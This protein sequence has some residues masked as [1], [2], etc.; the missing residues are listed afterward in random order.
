[1]E[2]ASSKI[3]QNLVRLT[4]LDMVGGSVVSIADVEPLVEK[5]DT[6]T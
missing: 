6:V 3:I 2:D 4:T 1:M 5:C